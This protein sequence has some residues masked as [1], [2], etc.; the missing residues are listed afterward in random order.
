MPARSASPG[1]SLKR[2]RPCR[3]RPC[4]ETEE[5]SAL[6]RP[7]RRHWP[8]A[9]LRHGH[10]P[11]QGHARRRRSCGCR[12][13]LKLMPSRVPGLRGAAS[14]DEPGSSPTPCGGAGWHRVA[15]FHALAGRRTRSNFIWGATA[16]MLPQSLPTAHCLS[17]RGQGPPL[18]SPAMNFFAVL[19]ALLCA[20]AQALGHGNQVHEAVISWIRW[21]GRNFDAGASA[22]RSGGLVHHGAGAGLW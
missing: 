8:V 9:G 21:T 11:G 1:G 7:H 10:R 6:P 4:C 17:K 5:K 12:L 20:A 3:H 2:M 15:S 18:S 16:A 22:S 19:L 13:G 14:P